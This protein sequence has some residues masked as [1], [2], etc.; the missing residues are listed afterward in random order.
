MKRFVLFTL[1]ITALAFAGCSDD[2]TNIT[3][4]G[5]AGNGGGASDPGPGP[6][7]Q[8]DAEIGGGSG[9]PIEIEGDSEATVEGTNDALI[10]GGQLLIT[11]TSTDGTLISTVLE[12]GNDVLPGSVSITGGGPDGSFVNITGAA[13]I[14]NST[15]GSVTVDQCPE[16]GSVFTGSW[17]VEL[18]DAMGMGEGQTLSGTFR[19]TVRIDDGSIT[20]REISTGGGDAGGGGGTDAGGGATCDLSVCD[21]P[22]CPLQ[23][24][25]DRCVLQCATGGP[26]DLMSP[27]FNPLECISCVEQCMDIY[28]DDPACGGPARALD[29]CETNSGCDDQF[30]PDE[31]EEEYQECALAACCDEARAAF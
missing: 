13:G 23:D 30:D 5:D 18:E 6:A 7:N 9:G 15:G 22:C 1:C 17:N 20:C 10:A 8:V 12:P 14:F 29:E 2:D 27:D 24:E 11:L 31:E 25:Y 4:N 19:A 28:F 21:G 16:A 26:C 3:V